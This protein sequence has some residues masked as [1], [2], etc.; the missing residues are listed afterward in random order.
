MKSII[1]YYILISLIN[2][3]NF[4][5]STEP[6]MSEIWDKNKDNIMASEFFCELN[7]GS[8]C[9]KYTY[10]YNNAGKTIFYKIKKNQTTS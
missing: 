8:V 2:N 3:C 5:G 4:S 7:P 9:I 1:I 10:K 6:N